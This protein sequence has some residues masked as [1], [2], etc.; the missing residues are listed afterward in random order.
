MCC[1]IRPQASCARCVGRYHSCLRL[2]CCA[3]FCLLLLMLVAVSAAEL[4]LCLNS[5]RP[6]HGPPETRRP[7]CAVF[8]VSGFRKG[9]RV[10]GSTRAVAVTLQLLR[11]IRHIPV[12]LL[13]MHCRI[14][15]A[16][17]A[18][19]AAARNW[20]IRARVAPNRRHFGPRPAEKLAFFGISHFAINLK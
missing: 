4:S 10:P 7:C 17:V 15:Q 14:G 11:H 8:Q 3:V 20:P 6:V 5:H 18:V 2:L 19:L 12:L 9:L 1:G 13:L 16:A